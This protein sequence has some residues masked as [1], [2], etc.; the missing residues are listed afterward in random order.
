MLDLTSQWLLFGVCVGLVTCTFAVASGRATF[1]SPLVFVVTLLVFAYG[2]RGILT[3][4]DADRFGVF[5][6]FYVAQD[7]S[8][9]L[10]S[11]SLFVLGTLSL[12]AGYASRGHELVGRALP[13]LR[14]TSVRRLYWVSILFLLAGLVAFAYLLPVLLSSGAVLGL[15]ERSSRLALTAAWQGRGPLL[16]LVFQGTLFLVCLLY[17]MTLQGLRLRRIVLAVVVALILAACFAF[18]GSRQNLLGVL[19]AFL[20]FYH[21][22]IRIIPLSFQALFGAF[23]VLVGGLLGLMLD[24]QFE[25]VQGEGGD[26]WLIGAFIRFGKTFD[27]FDMLSAYVQKSEEFF[28]GLP[29]IEDL[30]LTYLPRELFPFKPEV[31]GTVRLQNALFPHLYD[32]AGLSATYPIGFFGEAYANF[33]VAGVIVLPFIFGAL[34]RALVV[35]AAPT[36]EGSLYVVVIVALLATGPGLVRG[37]GGAILAVILTVAMLKILFCFRLGE[38]RIP[39]GAGA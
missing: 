1:L 23:A 31:F 34:L 21:Y 26:S 24:Q 32:Y 39:N 33:H 9:F 17:A 13:S 15:F 6:E 27:Q 38:R 5:V 18:M 8:T 28:F 29:I 4:N 20:L 3:A 19:L 25:T 10:I 12:I 7:L 30:L 37:Y 11:F 14:I 16:F 36:N 22:R 35:R 2:I